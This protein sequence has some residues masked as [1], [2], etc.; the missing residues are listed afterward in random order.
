MVNC[1]TLAK[2]TGLI[3]VIALCGIL[4]PQLGCTADG[5]DTADETS[6]SSDKTSQSSDSVIT[7]RVS[8]RIVT[9]SS[10]PVFTTQDGG[11][12]LCR[13]LKGDKF[14]FFGFTQPFNRMI[15]WCPRGVPPSQGTTGFAQLAGTVDGGCG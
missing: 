2:R 1:N 12:V 14:S 9:A 3:A 15:T 13:F 5:S 4:A 7:P 10:I 6:Q 8:C 11:T